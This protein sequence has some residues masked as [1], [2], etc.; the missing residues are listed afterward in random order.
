MSNQKKDYKL[1]CKF[2]DELKNS[3]WIGHSRKWWP[4]F[5]YHFTDIH[6]AVKIIENGNLFC[7][8]ILEHD[9]L[10]DNDNASPEII[11]NTNPL[12]KN[13]VRLYF[14][15]RTPT[16]YNNEG[17]RP[18]NK[19]KFGGAHCPV[20]IYFLFDSK[21]ILSM[22]ETSFSEGSLASHSHVALYNDYNG[23]RTIP[24]Q[25]VYHDSPLLINEEKSKIKFHR[26]AEVVIP[27]KLDLTN[28]RYIWCRTSAEFETLK[29]LLSRQSLHKWKQR[30]G[31]G[32]KSNLFFREWTFVEEVDLS[33]ENV[34]I[35]FNP[36]SSAPGPFKAEVHIKEE[37]TGMTYKWTKEDFYS[38]EPRLVI[39]LRNLKDPTSYTFK[40]LLDNNMAFYGKH[41]EEMYPF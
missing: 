40:L 9:G 21:S 19:L 38:T 29:N 36:T 24:F 6:N 5:V 2:I 37:N 15:P 35:K 34:T 8:K 16:Q 31:T 12:W 32:A 22:E 18:Q 7:R 26:H 4:D 33:D 10:M 28:L 11:A 17:F 30:I 3:E 1:I 41:E 39:G 13:F 25:S 27:Q 23:F 20:P 14:R